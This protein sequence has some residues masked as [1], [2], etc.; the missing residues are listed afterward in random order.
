MIIFTLLHLQSTTEPSRG[1]IASLERTHIM[2]LYRATFAGSLLLNS[3]VLLQT[4]RSH[5]TNPIETAEPEKTQH[6]GREET[7]RES[8]S[9]LKWRFFPTYLLVNAADWLQG[10]YIYPIYKGML[11][12]FL[13]YGKIAD[14]SKMRRVFQ[15]RQLRSF[16]L[17]V[18]SQ[19]EYPHRS[20]ERSQIVTVVE[21]LAWHIAC[22]TPSQASHY[23]QTTFESYFWVG[24]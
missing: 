4:Y 7:D 1:T 18:S 15:K 6:R 10:P 12:Q 5:Q 22:C 16:S 24:C 2:D 11:G 20:R 8:L 21:R 19:L 3:F 17:S 23:S 13:T 14:R 9:K